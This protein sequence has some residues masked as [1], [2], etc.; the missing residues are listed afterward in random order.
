MRPG[1][2]QFHGRADAV[3]DHMTGHMRE[4][5][6]SQGNETERAV[7]FHLSTLLTS[8]PLSCAGELWLELCIHNCIRHLHRLKCNSPI[9]EKTKFHSRCTPKL[10]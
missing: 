3:P 1:S 5:S 7:Q 6:V 9:H 8:Y 4:L 10:Q 2:V